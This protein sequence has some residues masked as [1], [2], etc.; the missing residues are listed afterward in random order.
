MLKNIFSLTQKISQYED[1]WRWW[2]LYYGQQ[3]IWH[4]LWYNGFPSPLEEGLH[5]VNCRRNHRQCFFP[6][7]YHNIWELSKIF[8]I[9]RSIYTPTLEFEGLPTVLFLCYDLQNT[10]YH[11]NP[12]SFLGEKKEKKHCTVI[13]F[14]ISVTVTS[15][16]QQ[17]ISLP[18]PGGKGP[19]GSFS[20]DNIEAYLKT[21]GHSVRPNIIIFFLNVL[22]LPLVL[23]TIHSG[24]KKGQAIFSLF[25][26][27]NTDC[28]II[29]YDLCSCLHCFQSSAPSLFLPIANL[30]V[31]GLQDVQ[32]IEVLRKHV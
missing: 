21:R 25:L 9:A 16:N 12:L 2:F 14:H 23:N 3:S 26:W 24:K 29:R 15:W 32:F 27:R 8:L 19:S 10:P 7:P 22:R 20:A 1:H 5:F 4:L 30:R 11:L 28:V 17:L 6:S 31:S 13:A 18:Q